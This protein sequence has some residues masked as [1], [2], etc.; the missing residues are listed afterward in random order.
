MP[1]STVCWNHKDRGRI[2]LIDDQMQTLFDAN[3]NQTRRL[4]S[5]QIKILSD[6]KK[7]Q[8]DLNYRNDSSIDSN[9]L[10]FTIHHSLLDPNGE[11][12]TTVLVRI[13]GTAG[14]QFVEIPKSNLLWIKEGV[15]AQVVLD[16]QQK[17]AVFDKNSGTQQ[18][19][20]ASTLLKY[21]EQRK[22]EFKE[23]F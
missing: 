12:S 13:P 8:I 23:L 18:I 16:R 14:Q 21:F 15:T 7:A 2:Y 17:V 5:E 1:K 22:K 10:V 4:T 3:G 20:E 9:K 19:Q 6:Q 11:T